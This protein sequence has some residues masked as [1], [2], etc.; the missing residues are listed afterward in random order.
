MRRNMMLYLQ[1]CSVYCIICDMSKI[2][3]TVE[4]SIFLLLENKFPN[5]YTTDAKS[6]FCVPAQTVW[7]VYLCFSS[8]AFL[9]CTSGESRAGC[10]RLE[11]SSKDVACPKG[12]EFLRDYMCHYRCSSTDCCLLHFKWNIIQD[13]L[14]F[15]L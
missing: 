4:A 8:S 10:Q 14:D 11:R 3:G 5:R 6:Y 15:H 7:A 9:N 2:F 13:L 12:N 1:H